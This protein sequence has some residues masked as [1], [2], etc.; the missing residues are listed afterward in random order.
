MPAVVDVV[1]GA[2]VVVVVGD[3]VVDVEARVVVVVLCFGVL[4]LLLQAARTTAA[5]TTRA[6][7][8]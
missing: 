5:P 2:D 1:A 7:A 6:S 8:Q 4:G 3:V